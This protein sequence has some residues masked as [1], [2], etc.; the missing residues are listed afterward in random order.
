[1]QSQLQSG[2][3]AAWALPH[4]QHPAFLQQHQQMAA[5]PGAYPGAAPA[6]TKGA[7]H[8]YPPQHMPMPHGMTAEQL[9]ALQQAPWTTSHMIAQEH[10]P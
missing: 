10:R 5:Q 2:Q 8:M 9:A 6:A 4:P 3:P 7:P 1:M